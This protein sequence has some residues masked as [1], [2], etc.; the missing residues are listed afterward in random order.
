MSR[1]YEYNS[2]LANQIRAY[3]TEKRALGRKYDKESKQFHEL[4]KFLVKAGVHLPELS[5]TVVERWIAKR[6]N[7]KRKNQR[8]RINFIKRFAS[9]LCS[10][11]YSAYYSA[12]KISSHDD[13]A[14]IPYIFTNDKLGRLIQYFDTLA[15]S[16][17]YPNGHLVLSLL[18]KTLIC[19]G[20]RAS[21]AANLKVSD[22]DFDK[23]LLTILEA[24]NDRKRYVPLSD[25]LWLLYRNYYGAVHGGSHQNDYFFPNARKNPHHPTRIYDIFRE[26]LWHCGIEHKGRGH[27]PRVHDFRHTFA[28]RCMQKLEKTKGDIVTSLPYLSAY[29]GHRNIMGSQVYLRL[30]AEH[31]PKLI[32][33]LCDF[34]GDTIPEWEVNFDEN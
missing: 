7:E 25:D 17:Q 4:D 23:G 34:L 27:G 11:G 2:G 22:V 30:I 32:E 28:V 33:K 13:T 18:Y 26:A 9:Y 31:H 24:K 29:L 15:P 19:C 21:E 16:R 14:F 6:P 3:I 20:L 10:K 1:V 12:I 8:Y 5:Q